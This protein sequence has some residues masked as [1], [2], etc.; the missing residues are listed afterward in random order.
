MSQESKIRGNGAT[1]TPEM[2]SVTKL[3]TFAEQIIR[4]DRE[5]ALRAQNNTT[6]L[7]A[8]TNDRTASKAR[9]G[10]L[11]ELCGKSRV[12][13]I[14]SNEPTEDHDESKLIQFFKPRVGS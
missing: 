13:K 11:D 7:I 3:V 4:A 1:K 6:D 10:A 12:V 2:L 5:A 14:K 9:L 8:S